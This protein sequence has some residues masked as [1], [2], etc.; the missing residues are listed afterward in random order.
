MFES[1]LLPLILLDCE[2]NRRKKKTI[3]LY[4]KIEAI[5]VAHGAFFFPI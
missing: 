1:R 5:M 2:Y 3:R 4:R